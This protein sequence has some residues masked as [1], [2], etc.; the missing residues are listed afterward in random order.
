M[1][2]GKVDVTIENIVEDLPEIS[3]QQVLYEAITNSIQADAT[4]IDVKFVYRILDF[5]KKDI[6][7]NVKILESIEIID[8]GE[9]FIEKNIIAFKE[10]KTKN[11]ITLGCK[12]IGRFLY[13]KLFKKVEIESLDKKIDFVIDKNPETINN[14]NYIDKTVIKLLKPKKKITINYENLEN[15]LK[16]HFIA[17]FKLLKDKNKK[18]SINIYKDDIK[19]FT[20]KSDNI[21][22]FTSKEFT[23]KTH[24]FIISYVFNDDNLPNEGYY[25]AGKRV[26]KKNSEL[27]QS[28]KIKLFKQFK[29]LFLLE[30]KYL[31]ENVKSDTRDDFAIYPK[32]KNSEDL[33]GSISWE[34]INEKMKKIIEDIA[35]E[36]RIDLEKI[37]KENRIKAVEQAPYLGFYIGK[38]EEIL[39]SEE[40]ISLAKKRLDED[41]KFLRDKENIDKNEFNEK[42]SLVTQ[43][44][45]AEYIFDREKVIEK[46]KSLTD[47]N[48]IEKEIHNLFMKQKTID[49]RNS[50]KS[51]HLWLFDDRFM[52]YDKIFSEKQIKEI[53]PNLSDNLDRPDLLSI[54]SN[55]YEKDLITDI[56]V[57]ELKRPNEKIITPAGAEEQLLDYASY[58]NDNFEDRKIRIWTYAFL[59]FSDTFERKFKNKGYNRVFTNSEYPLY[60]KAYDEVN[61]IINFIDYKTLAYDAELR[62]K[63]FLKILKGE[64]IELEEDENGNTNTCRARKP[65]K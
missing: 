45:L 36:N 57:I 62:N 60:Y 65:N 27:D 41:K 58:I 18:V 15:N 64:T 50:Y 2:K 28:K 49:D 59:K 7:D 17:Y 30:S 31:D 52:T 26:V 12:G 44:E 24:K 6:K 47:E 48:S 46:L 16:E 23:I 42:L 34:E 63:T 4:Q 21:P 37:A 9:G 56:V 40:L 3:Y 11:K 54:I 1:N 32:R 13:L 38:N 39:D 8:N 5:D 61:A 29:I 10:Y 22:K 35:K 51:N 19:K 14:K 33:Y 53:F 55:T 43:T 20:I 25:C